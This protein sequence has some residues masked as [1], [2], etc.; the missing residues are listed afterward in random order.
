M[1]DPNKHLRFGISRETTRALNG[2]NVVDA[3]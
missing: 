3:H 2:G 1:A